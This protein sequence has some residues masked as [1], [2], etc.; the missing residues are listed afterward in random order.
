LQLERHIR[1][2]FL[3]KKHQLEV[4]EESQRH[5]K[6]V[7]KTFRDFRKKEEVKEPDPE[8]VFVSVC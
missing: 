3:I 7:V 4:M 2:V 1:A 5:E 8:P 6:N